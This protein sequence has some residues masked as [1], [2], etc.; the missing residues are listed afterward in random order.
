MGIVNNKVKFVLVYDGSAESTEVLLGRAG[1]SKT[2]TL[3]APCVGEVKRDTM[4]LA[5]NRISDY[6]FANNLSQLPNTSWLFDHTPV[7]NSP[8]DR[9]TSVLASVDA[10]FEKNK[11]IPKCIE[12][13]DTPIPVLFAMHIPQTEEEF[14]ADRQGAIKALVGGLF[15]TDKIL[16]CQIDGLRFV[17]LPIGATGRHLHLYIFPKRKSLK[18]VGKLD[19][20]SKLSLKAIDSQRKK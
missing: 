12:G 8:M 4:M 13:T 3:I 19:A 9:L 18:R 7:S 1:F 16:F 5:L 17:T 6:C 10:F 14:S 20:L 2:E 11:K 15:D